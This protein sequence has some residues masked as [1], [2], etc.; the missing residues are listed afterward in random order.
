MEGRGLLD[1]AGGA[2]IRGSVIR[3]I[4]LAL[5]LVA[6]VFPGHGQ[7]PRPADTVPDLPPKSSNSPA[8]IDGLRLRGSSRRFLVRMRISSSITAARWHKAGGSM[9]RAMHF[10]PAVA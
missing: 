2:S 8:R 10:S 9:M 4:K 1:V 6:A 3:S 5:F 7:G